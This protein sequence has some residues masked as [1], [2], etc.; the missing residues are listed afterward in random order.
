MSRALLFLSSE[1]LPVEFG[2]HQ[3]TDIIILTS[4]ISLTRI[5]QSLFYFTSVHSKVTLDQRQVVY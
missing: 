4:I 5:N 2:R 3:Q 1:T